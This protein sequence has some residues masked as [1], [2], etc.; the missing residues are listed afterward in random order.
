MCSPDFAGC[1]LASSTRLSPVYF[2]YAQKY[3]IQGH[4]R[5]HCNVEQ[6]IWIDKNYENG[7]SQYLSKLKYKKLSLFEARINWSN[8][9]DS[10]CAVVDSIQV[11]ILRWWFRLMSGTTCGRGS[12]VSSAVKPYH[13]STA[14]LFF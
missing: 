12:V 5:N 8:L 3:R 11:V 6:L 7:F 13:N 4:H 10:C 1:R 14:R 9:L 2:C